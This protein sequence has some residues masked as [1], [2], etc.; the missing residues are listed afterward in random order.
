MGLFTMEEL[1]W[2]DD[3]HPWVAPGNLFTRG[4]GSYKIPSANDI[5]CE[6]NV[7]LL[8]DSLNP[9]ATYSSKAIGEPPLFLGSTVYF[10]IRNA[11][12]SARNDFGL[13]GTFHFDS[14][15]TTERIRMS[16]QDRFTQEFVQDANFRVKGSF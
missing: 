9:Y 12:E 15:A 7:H 1:I 5:P 6:F 14:P 8:K 4:P 3:A 16:C 11:V 2:G 10:A 13:K